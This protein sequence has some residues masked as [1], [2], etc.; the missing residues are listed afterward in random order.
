MRFA[1]ATWRGISRL[2]TA[3]A[4]D[5]V[6]FLGERGARL[7]D[8]IPD[9]EERFRARTA[10]ESVATAVSAVRRL[11]LAPHELADEGTLDLGTWNA[12]A[13]EV[14]TLLVSVRGAV[15]RLRSLYPSA[16]DR[17]PSTDINSMD[18]DFAFDDGDF[19]PE[20]GPQVDRALAEDTGPIPVIG[21]LT[22]MLDED[23]VRFGQRMRSPS[24]VADRWALLGELHELKNNCLQ[25]L[26]AVAAAVLRPWTDQPVD[27]WLPDFASAL[28]RVV[29]L[30]ARVVDLHREASELQTLLRRDLEQAPLV[31]RRVDEMLRVFAADPSYGDLRPLDKQQFLQLRLW[32]L[33]AAPSYDGGALKLEDFVRCLEVML[34]I[35]R[36]ATLRDH[37]RAQ[38][39]VVIMLLESD[40]D[41]DDVMHQLEPVYGRWPALD[42]QLRAWRARRAPDAEAVLEQAYAARA[43]LE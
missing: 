27:H 3:S 18:L 2:L 14:R 8:S 41:V 17:D 43:A 42:E 10:L 13:P 26:D 33:Q 39:N 1:S 9:L 35:N 25:C 37:D 28:T 7:L 24:L 34:D 11:D 20:R 23:L 32:L 21:S 4:T 16:A 38:L 30:R 31:F 40:E 15:E 12:L 22:G 19:G 29:R 36:R 5:L 6:A